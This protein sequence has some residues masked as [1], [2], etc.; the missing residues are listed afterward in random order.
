MSV[1]H[2]KVA[3]KSDVRSLAKYVFLA[4][5]EQELLRAQKLG[6]SERHQKYLEN[7]IAAVQ[8]S[9]TR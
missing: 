2:T 1:L 8:Q 5:K 4:R 3:Y 9:L 6:L 7:V